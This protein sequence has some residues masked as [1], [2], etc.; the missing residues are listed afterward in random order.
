M[1]SLHFEIRHAFE[2]EGIVM[3]EQMKRYFSPRGA[4]RGLVLA[5]VAL[6]LW[7]CWAIGFL[8]GVEGAI[9]PSTLWILL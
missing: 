3:E 6:V 5:A 9:T 2:M 4:M 8:Q 7:G 1:L